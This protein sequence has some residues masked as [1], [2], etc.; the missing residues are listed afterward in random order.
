[1]RAMLPYYIVN[2]FTENTFGGNPAAVMV[3]DQ[4]LDESSLLRR[5]SELGAK[6]DSYASEVCDRF[7]AGVVDRVKALVRSCTAV[8]DDEKKLGS[9]A[10]CFH[11]RPAIGDALSARNFC[12]MRPER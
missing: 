5:F 2:A 12:G 10:Y 8:V 3:L 7:D 11:A 9:F 4:W 1:M 6:L